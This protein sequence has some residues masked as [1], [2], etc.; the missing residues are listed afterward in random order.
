MR[1]APPSD[2]DQI[3]PGALGEQFNLA[4]DRPGS[5]PRGELVSSPR[6][7]GRVRRRT[8]YRQG[9]GVLPLAVRD[10]VGPI[11]FFPGRH[12]GAPKVRP[13]RP[14]HTCVLR[15]GHRQPGGRVTGEDGGRDGG[16][17]GVPQQPPSAAPRLLDC[18][19]IAPS[20]RQPCAIDLY[21]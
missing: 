13:G 2:P 18:G 10:A 8:A 21:P 11:E 1:S 12:R 4:P 3:E 5:K 14:L 17:P 15:L 7:G 16:T 19:G 6:G 9:G 20:D